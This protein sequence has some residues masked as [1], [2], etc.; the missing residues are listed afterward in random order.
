MLLASGSVTKAGQDI[1]LRELR[2]RIKKRMTQK[3]GV[4]FDR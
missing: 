1:C 3:C 2:E 4:K